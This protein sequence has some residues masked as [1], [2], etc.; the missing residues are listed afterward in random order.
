MFIK[1]LHRE[2][3]TASNTQHKWP[4]LV[5]LLTDE[6]HWSLSNVLPYIF[7]EF[8]FEFFWNLRSHWNV[9]QHE[10]WSHGGD[11]RSWFFN[12]VF[13]IPLLLSHLFSMLLSFYTES[14]II[15][16]S[17]SPIGIY[18]HI[19]YLITHILCTY[20]IYLYNFG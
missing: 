5:T 7:S 20:F 16:A 9:M 4:G 11:I 17:I 14:W 3:S 18:L 8:Y 10:A 12:W 1:G 13:Y 15:S 19:V 2:E 6:F